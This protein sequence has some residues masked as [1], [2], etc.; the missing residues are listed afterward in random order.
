MWQLSAQNRYDDALQLIDNILYKQQIDWLITEKAI[1]LAFSGEYTQYISYKDVITYSKNYFKM[2]NFYRFEVI[3]YAID[4]LLNRYEP[5]INSLYMNDKQWSKYIKYF[6]YELYMAISKYKE[7]NFDEA[8]NFSNELLA[9]N[10][11]FL[12]FTAYVV[13]IRS[14]RKMNDSQM[15]KKY[16][17]MLYKDPRLDKYREGINI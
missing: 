5:K 15:E 7:D 10:Y 3:N 13:L 14:Y 2:P 6:Y 1:I 9:T 12:K 16:E 17:E 11:E 4:F 8:I